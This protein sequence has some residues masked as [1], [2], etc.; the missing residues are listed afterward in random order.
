LYLA[1]AALAGIAFVGLAA[2]L[3]RRTSAFG[4]RSLFGYSILYLVVIFA[5]LLAEH[6]VAN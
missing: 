3:M 4:A 5:T 6:L 1:V 2:R